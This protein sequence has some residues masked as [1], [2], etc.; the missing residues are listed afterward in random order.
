MKLQPSEVFAEY[1]AAQNFKASIGNKG[2]FEQTKINDRFYSGD[3]WYSAENSNSRPLVRHNVIKRIGDY[4]MSQILKENISINYTAKGVPE[5]RLET[6]SE[7]FLNLKNGDFK[8]G[9]RVEDKEIAFIMKA[10]SNYRNQL[11]KDMKLDMLCEKALKNAY[12]SGTGVIYTYWDSFAETGLFA[13]SERKV[14]IMGEI[15]S[16]V[17]DIENLYFA[18]NENCD[19]QSQK[20]I[21]I[22][23]YIDVEDALRQA[24]QNNLSERNCQS[25]LSSAENGKVLTLTK[26]Y[27]SFLKDG[28]VTVMC[29]KFCE[30]VTLRES[31]DT[32]LSLYPIAL[33]YWN[34]RKNSAYGD[35]DITYLIPNQIAIN[36]MITANV[37]SAVTMGM[38]IMVVNGDTV[39]DNITNDPGQIIK[40]YGSNEDVAGAVKYVTPPDSCRDF[41][42]GIERLI[43]DTLSQCGANEV[44]LG[45]STPDNAAALSTMLN[46][47]TLPL[48][49]IKRRYRF[50]LEEIALIWAEFWFKLYKNRPL[51]TE[52]ENGSF[53]VPF[54]SE[55]YRGILVAATAVVKSAQSEVLASEKFNM[56]SK[57]Y[58]QGVIEKGVFIKELPFEFSQS[59]NYSIARKEDENDRT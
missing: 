14:K 3:Q 33:F 8:V 56:L 28:S 58:E 19:L 37:W 12:I 54:E 45:D 38:P 5:S 7:T 53:L 51:K 59:I 55:R 34:T 49:L 35:S 16:E 24:R 48:E 22:S 27:K 57:L 13:D 20:Y 2:L 52:D 39:P 25:I 4:K 10:I 17:L 26:L 36:K 18:D 1:K 29:A 46:A 50:F 47:A 15:K 32:K 31:Y 42:T 11:A 23:R 44:A 30:N 40:I 9:K 6:L 21:I 41:G 43:A